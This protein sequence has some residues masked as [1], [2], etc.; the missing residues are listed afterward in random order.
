PVA[1]KRFYGK[2]FGWECDDMPGGPGMTYT[3]CRVKTHYAAGLYALDQRMMS[4]GVPPY[5][6]P[7]INVRNAD[8][9]AKKAAQGGVRS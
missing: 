7:F 5:W 2:L 9:L 6:L 8:D 1:A 4:Q 3:M